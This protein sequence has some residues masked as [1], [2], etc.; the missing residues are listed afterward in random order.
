MQARLRRRRNGSAE[1]ALV[2]AKLATLSHGGDRRS[3][4]F[5]RPCLL[6]SKT[7]AAQVSLHENTIK[8]AREIPGPRDGVAPGVCRNK[9]E[10]L[11]VGMRPHREAFLLRFSVLG[12]SEEILQKAAGHN[13][14]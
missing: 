8:R 5:K 4:D 14:T 1:L 13:R 7:L 10:T 2:S 11:G 6:I 9:Q 3:Y 12:P